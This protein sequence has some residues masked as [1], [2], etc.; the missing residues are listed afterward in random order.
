MHRHQVEVRRKMLG[1]IFTGDAAFD[2]CASPRELAEREKSPQAASGSGKASTRLAWV[3]RQMGGSRVR[4]ERKLWL[5]LLVLVGYAQAQALV[6]T[7]DGIDARSR[8]WVRYYAEMYQLPTEFVE[9]IIDQESAW[10]PQ[11]V[12]TKGAVGL[13]QLMPR[14][15]ARFGVQNRF[16]IEQNIRGG[17]AYLAWLKRRF[18]ADL[19]LVTA[20]YYA[21]EAP[22][23]SR[24]LTFANPD[25]HRYVSQVAAR[26]RERRANDIAT[27]LPAK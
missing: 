10:D 14:T 23:Q 18:N 20:A 8:A 15:A 2:P 26:Y 16:R 7:A 19:R 21:G 5:A 4:V 3:I 1:C 12:S 22:I 9:A 24:G 27:T 13:M 17:V 6:A 25:V 11:A